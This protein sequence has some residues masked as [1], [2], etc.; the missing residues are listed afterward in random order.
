M[1]GSDTHAV[2]TSLHRWLGLTPQPLTIEFLD[3]AVEAA[4]EEK[5]DLDFKLDPPSAGA[6]A[7][8]DLAKDLAAMANSGG[9]ML[10]FGIRDGAS[11]AVEAPGVAADFATD[12][13]VR[14]L[15]RVALN[16]IS[17]PILNLAV[18]TMSDDS[19]HGLAVVVPSTDEAPHLI[20]VGD[21]FRA[22][23]RNGPDTAW[24]TERMLE[25]S[26]RARFNARRERED[27]LRGILEQAF[28]PDHAEELWIGAVARPVGEV[29][30]AQR[31]E[32]EQVQG[33]L[34]GALKLA[35]FWVRLKVHPLEWL[36]R[37]NPRPGLRRWVARFGRYGE[38]TRWREAQAQILDGGTITLISA[39]GQGRAGADIMFGPSEV[40][41]DRVETFIADFMAMLRLTAI[42]LGLSGYEIL[43]DFRGPSEGPVTLR[44]PDRHLRGYYLDPEYSSPIHHFVPVEALVDAAMSPKLF[45]DQLREIALDVVNQGGVQYLHSIEAAPEQ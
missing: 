13:Y 43:I 37:S 21:S 20:F 14:D 12:T 10:V 2:F 33:I 24:M 22:P 44:I 4:L 25:A 23:Y 11:R 3:A 27:E 34:D 39:M 45:L 30:F 7:Q 15:R 40:G 19:R 1:T 41:S 6:L 38:A 8:S 5:A 17:P 32:R 18:H 26:Y 29:P 16:R 36:D 28:V 42:E 31:L 9:G 35:G